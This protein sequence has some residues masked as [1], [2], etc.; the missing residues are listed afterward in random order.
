MTEQQVVSPGRKTGSTVAVVVVALVAVVLAIVALRLGSKVH[1]LNASVADFKA[2][3]TQAATE[4][5]QL[6]AQ[7]AEAKA[8]SAQLQAR[9]D[10]AKA[11]CAK[12]Q[13]EADE[14]KAGITNCRRRWM[15]PRPE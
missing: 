5:G 9:S 3:L 2:Q 11:R 7:L 4:K 15:K 6:Q 12:V 14:A 1:R 13:A 10:E 8:G